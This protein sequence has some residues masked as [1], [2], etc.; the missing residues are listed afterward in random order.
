MINRENIETLVKSC[1]EGTDLFIVDIQVSSSNNIR[2][3]IDNDRGVTVKEC[4]DF[5][6][7]VE[8]GLDRDKEDFQLE[9][10]SPG[11]SEPLK[12]I[13]Q[14]KKN[15]G[16]DVEVVTNEGHK[17]QGRLTGL[18]PDGIKISEMTKVRGDKKRPEII[19]VERDLDFGHISST[20]VL[21][22]YK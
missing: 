9:V 16:R 13:E 3:L 19:Q 1:M 20:K 15:I 6:R 17:H 12:V 4:I 14:Y 11:L 10:S 22:S 18:T 21:V 2:I 5:S 8:N 7:A